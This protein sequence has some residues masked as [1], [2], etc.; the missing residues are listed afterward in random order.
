MFRRLGVGVSRHPWMVI[1]T[2]LVLTLTMAGAAAFGYGHGGLFERMATSDFV[3][4]G[5]ESE[6]VT[7]FTAADPQS[8]ESVI[9]VVEG[10]DL[11]DGSDSVA[12]FALEYR[13][14]LDGVGVAS[15]VDPF[16]SGDPADS[17]SQ[18]MLSSQ[19]DGYVV[20]VRME[21]DLSDSAEAES[22]QNL[23][24]GIQEYDGRLASTFG[25]AATATEVSDAAISDST[26]ELIQR[27]L[28][29]GESVSL[30]VAA[31]LM[32]V[33]FG[34]VLAACMPLIGAITAILVGLGLIWVATFV[35][36]IDSFILNVVSIIGV[37][38]SIDYGLLVV[39]RFREE[40]AKLMD[41]VDLAGPRARPDIVEPAVTEAVAMAGRTVA[42][43]AIT[44]ACAISGLMTMRLYVLKTISLGGIVVTLLAVL[45][46]I[47]LVPA[48]LTILG[49]KILG[50]SPVTRVPVLSAL[51]RMVSDSSSDDGVFSRIARRVQAHP[52]R[53]MA[54]TLALLVM[55]TLPLHSFTMRSNMSDYIPQDS[56][57]SQAYGT[58]QANYPALATPS[59]QAVVDIPVEDS[60]TVVSAIEEINGI[61]FVVAQPLDSDPTMTL[62][63]VRVSAADQTGS[64]VSAVMEQMR[65]MDVGSR[66][67][68]GGAAALQRD[69]V[70]SM[71]ADAPLALAVVVVAVMVLLFLMTGSLLV[72]IKALIINS[73]SLLA[74]LGA[75][76][77]IFQQGIGVPVTDGLVA[78]IVACM[79]AFG[80]GLA[81]DYEV[82][83]LARIK[84]YWDAGES[85]DLAVEK[86]LQRS[87]RIITSAA[88]IIV[89]VFI[90]FATGEMIAI[91][92]I[93]V[94]LA[95]M[96]VTDATITRLLLVPAT[97][98]VLG[99]WNW[100]AP[101]PLQ[102]LAERVGFRE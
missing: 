4:P 42:F 56:A 63:N 88:A 65:D 67:W 38:L 54:G 2:W 3:V 16:S 99:K 80:F 71:T 37:A 72:P 52:W 55:M 28:I 27:D 40:G 69:I 94:A 34:G 13:G 6:A 89:A 23:T 83:L 19:G 75:T 97:M 12:A 32:V 74:A 62:I 18:A 86:G 91:E 95:I 35:I 46:A 57:L 25:D 90:G 98:T 79:I 30:P 49:R 59:V 26:M 8:G 81:M 20:V 44:I 5:S 48:L 33:V 92:Q 36:S 7:D 45:A 9:I 61:D 85:N 101:R 102:R 100:W 15:V 77:F 17:A 31:V 87:G 73:L 22:R 53:V 51:V 47:T 78:F 29:R 68:V 58:L 21:A 43:S 96:V 84:E 24:N 76:S 1:L 14:L 41:K 10:V 82:F 11:R 60:D 93:G 50:V 66:M 39:A 64:E 70:D